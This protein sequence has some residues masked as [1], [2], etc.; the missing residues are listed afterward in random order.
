MKKWICQLL[1]VFYCLAIAFPALVLA[2]EAE[3]EDNPNKIPESALE[4]SKEN[5]YPNSAVDLPNLQPSTL[6]KNLLESSEV[7]IDNPELIKMMNESTVKGS[8]LAIGMN[9]S[10]YLGHW[11]LSYKSEETNLNWNYE[12]I[13]TNMVDNRGGEQ[14]KN[15]QYSQEQQKRITGGLTSEVPDIDMVKNMLLIKAAEN[16]K[17]PLSYSTTIGFG[18]QA[19]RQF[20]V[21]AKTL[22]Y[23]S[24]YASAVNEKGVVTYGEVYLRLK[25][26]D[27]WLEV[28]N[29]TRQRIGATI[30]VQDYVNFKMETTKEPR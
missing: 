23:L 2:E 28:K 6:A 13:N 19:D 8:K 4:I 5:T 3:N 14:Q 25:G 7:D 15:I 9:V 30:P 29:V 16:T 20:Q 27:S 26:D 24:A 21:S 18:T 22:G 17:L 12:K 1:L 10:I 11:P